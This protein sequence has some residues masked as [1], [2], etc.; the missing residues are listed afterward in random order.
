MTTEKLSLLAVIQTKIQMNN[1]AAA[2][3]SYELTEE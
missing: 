3:S 2:G 1:L